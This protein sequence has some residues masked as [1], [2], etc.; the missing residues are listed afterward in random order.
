MNKHDMKTSLT[1]MLIGALL[2]LLMSCML[3]INSA[4]AD[5]APEKMTIHL[6]GKVKMK[7]RAVYLGIDGNAL[8]ASRRVKLGSREEMGQSYKNQ[9][10]DTLV[11][12]CFVGKRNGKK[13]WLYYLGETEVRQDQWDAVMGWVTL[14][15]KTTGKNSG[16]P[17]TGLTMGEIYT[18]I[19]GINAWMLSKEQSHLPKYKNA[20]AFCRLPTEAEWEFAARG[21]IRVEPEVF[22]R[23]YPYTDQNGNQYPGAYEWFRSNS[24]NRLQMC[25]S[26]HIKPNPIGLYDML[27]NVEELTL[28][29]FGPE[30]QQGR[31][32]QFVIRGGNFSTAENKL[33]ASYRTEYQPFLEDTGKIRRPPKIGFRLALGT[34]ISSSGVNPDQ[35]D[36]GYLDYARGKSLTRPGP[37]GDSSP[38]RQAEQDLIQFKKEELDRL[39]SEN[40]GLSNKIAQLDKYNHRVQT[41]LSVQKKENKHLNELMAEKEEEIKDLERQIFLLAKKKNVDFN[42]AK[43]NGLKSRIADLEKKLKTRRSGALINESTADRME[44]LNRQIARKDQHITDLKRRI[45]RFNHEFGKNAGRVRAVEK[46][47]LEALMRQ[48][49]ANAYIGFRNLKA[50]SLLKARKQSIKGTANKQVEGEQMVRDY[51][52]LVIQIVGETQKDLFPEVKGELSDCLQAREVKNSR[53]YQRKALNLLER[54]VSEVRNGRYLKPESLIQSFPDEP[55]FNR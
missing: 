38:S 10:T 26:K 47:Y 45:S 35:L 6:P 21:G 37:F 17:K 36:T 11:S 4:D 50:L 42:T 32:G 16:F 41:D 39:E 31:F 43:I 27:G 28:S 12:G 20:V 53:G 49:S 46:R 25:G 2:G 7:F 44:R 29:L 33:S 14:N 40:R 48:A 9:L 1:T 18:F 23:R 13:D 24:G 22:D 34:R 5:N 30:Y 19:D 15:K 52:N 54:H 3:W 55:E 51:C 8:F